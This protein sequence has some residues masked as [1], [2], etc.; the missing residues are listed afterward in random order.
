MAVAADAP[1]ADGAAGISRKSSSF[2]KKSSRYLKKSSSYEQKWYKSFFIC[3]YAF[4]ETCV[5]AQKIACKTYVESLIPLGRK[6]LQ[7][8]FESVTSEFSQG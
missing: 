7:A 6:V 1:A 2:P 3:V 5:W 8:N 4:R